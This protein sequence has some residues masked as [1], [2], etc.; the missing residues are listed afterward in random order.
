MVVVAEVDTENAVVV[1]MGRA[2]GL[3]AAFD[4]DLGL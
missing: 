4:T 1:G 2:E 3:T